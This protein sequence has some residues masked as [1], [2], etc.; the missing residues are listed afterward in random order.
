MRNKSGPP[1]QSRRPGAAGRIKAQADGIEE[2]KRQ[3]ILAAKRRLRIGFQ[4][5]LLAAIGLTVFTLIFPT[6]RLYMAQRAQLDQVRAQVAAAAQANEEQQAALKRWDDPAYVK[7][8]ARERLGYAM[9]GDRSYRVSDPENA[10][11]P[12]TPPPPSVAPTHLTAVDDAVSSDPWYAK[13]WE[14]SVKAG[15]AASG[16]AASG[17]AVSGEASP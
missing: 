5:V 6:L 16:Q 2:A 9:P 17:E 7:A 10:P 1:P 11:T 14:S 12:S 15:Q 3:E 4:I 8:Q 13:L